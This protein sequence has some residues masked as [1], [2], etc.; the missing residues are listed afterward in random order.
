MTN[1]ELTGYEFYGNDYTIKLWRREDCKYYSTVVY[2][3]DDDAKTIYTSKAQTN[4]TNAKRLGLENA[5]KHEK[6]EGK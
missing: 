2:E 5:K 4:E 1:D 3:T 6:E